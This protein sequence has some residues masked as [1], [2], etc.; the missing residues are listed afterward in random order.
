M[1]NSSAHALPTRSSRFDQDGNF[2]SGANRKRTLA[3]VI[4]LEH[5]RV[6]RNAR[7]GALEEE[8]TCIE[9]GASLGSC[10]CC[11]D[12]GHFDCEC[13][14]FMDG[15]L[16]RDFD[17]DH[18]RIAAQEEDGFDPYPDYYPDHDD[19][20][21]LGCSSMRTPRP[22]EFI[23]L[24]VGAGF[25]QLLVKPAADFETYAEMAAFLC[26]NGDDLAQAVGNENTLRELVLSDFYWVE[27]EHDRR[28]QRQEELFLESASFADPFEEPVTEGD[29]F[30]FCEAMLA[31]QELDTYPHRQRRPRSWRPM[32]GGG[33]KRF[34]NRFGGD[35]GHGGQC[36]SPSLHRPSAHELL[37]EA[38]LT[39]EDHGRKP[40][41]KPSQPKAEVVAD[42]AT[43]TTATTG[44][45]DNGGSKKQ[46]SSK[47]QSRHEPKEVKV[48]VL[49]R[50]DKFSP[51]HAQ[52]S[53]IV[54]SASCGGRRRRRH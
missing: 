12:C 43:D 37:T 47:K 16:D 27:H 13:S 29:A 14:S 49:S 41:T 40:K 2:R 11:T 17:D 53:L 18:H 21:G 31:D 38:F 1:L 24:D 7:L 51:V 33:W 28:R 52:V 23:E 39:Y 35:C 10:H 15:D 34:N 5:H 26:N 8:D 48:V 19:H 32:P 20:Y 44:A 3:R 9:C 22:S 42:S 4:D 36:D 50:R 6:L 25:V 54:V 30:D 46:G 45:N